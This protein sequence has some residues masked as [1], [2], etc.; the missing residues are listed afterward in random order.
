MSAVAGGDQSSAAEAIG[1][2]QVRSGTQHEL[3]DLGAALRPCDKKRCVLNEIPGIDVGAL[4]DEDAGHF[5][6][7]A[8]RRR[9]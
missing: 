9:Q 4:I 3:E 7:V 6:L 2:F 8:L 1:A 5:D